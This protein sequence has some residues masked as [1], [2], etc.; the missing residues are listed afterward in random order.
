MTDIYLRRIDEGCRDCRV[1]RRSLVHRY[2]ASEIRLNASIFFFSEIIVASALE[3][4]VYSKHQY[5]RNLERK[6]RTGSG[7]ASQ[8]KKQMEFDREK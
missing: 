3:M 8:E 5:G 1:V 6:I 2:V 4:S 7:Q